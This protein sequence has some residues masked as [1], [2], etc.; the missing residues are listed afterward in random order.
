VKL[1][2][3]FSVGLISLVSFS[4]CSDSTKD[5]ASEERLKAMAG[6]ELKEVVPVKGVVNV[7]GVPT[8]GVNL[9]LFR[10]GQFN[11]P[12]KDCRTDKEGKYCW[13][14]NLACDGIEP[15]KYFLAFTYIPKPKKN[16]EGVDLFKRKYQNPVK[17][18]FELT[19]VLGTPQEAMNYDLKSK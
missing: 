18:K 9:Y 1:R 17:N 2:L 6:G 16:D 7:D 12:I 15:G 8:E 19:V 10:D 11:S 3:L 5:D 14:T 13:S 4:G